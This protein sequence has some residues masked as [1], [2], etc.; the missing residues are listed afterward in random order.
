MRTHLWRIASAIALLAMLI[1]SIGSAY[2]APAES[3][4]A[5][6]SGPVQVVSADFVGVSQPLASLPANL[7]SQ[8][9]ITTAK[10]LRERFL[11]PKT[12]TKATGG[13]DTSIVQ[14]SPIGNSMPAVEANFA[15]VG[16]V[17][18]V[19]PP[20][21]NGDIGYDPISGTKYYMQWVNLSFQ[22][23]DVTNPAAVTSL[24]GP[25]A[26]NTLWAGT[27]TICASN[28]DG[29]PI[30]LFDHLANRWMISQF[31]LGFPDNFHQCVAVSTSAD[32]TGTWYLYDFKTSSSL[33]NDYPHFGVWPDGYY[34][35]VNQFDGTTYGWEG[36]GVAAFERDAMLQGL[37]AKM[38]YIDVGAKNINYG[39]MLP[40]DLDGPAPAPGTPNY[41]MEWDDSTWLGDPTDTLRI[42]E[43]RVNWATP[44]SST[45]GLN[46]NFAPNLI[47]ATAN[48]DPDMCGGNRNCIPQPGTTTKLDAIADRLM[49]RLQYRNFGSY[50][51]MVGN[52]TVDATSTDKAGVHWFEL[53]NSGSGWSMYQQGVYAPDTNNRWMG[54]IA[55][56]GSGNMALGYSVSSTSTYPS[57][58]YT[59]RLSGDP[60]NSLPQGESVLIAGGG[61]QTSTSGR[62]GDYSNMSVDPEDDCTFWYTQEYY[63]T[64]SNAGWLTRVGS[65]RF[66][67]CTNLPTGTLSGTVTNASGGAAIA[68]ATVTATGGYS[69]LTDAS[70][71]YTLAVP[72]GTYD[73]TASFYGF[74]S[75]TATGLSVTAGNTTTQ[76]FALNSSATYTISGKVTDAATGWPLYASIDIFGYPLGPIYTNPA[77]GTFSVN[78][79]ASSYTFTV[80]AMSG[81]YD[82]SV[83][84]VVVTANATQNFTLNADTLLCTAPGYVASGF[85]EGF[86]TWPLTGWSVV[87][88]KSSGLVWAPNTVYGDGNYTNG[89]GLAATVNSD[90]N[91]DIP[92]DTELRTPLIDPATL[93][94]KNLT[95]T[96]NYQDITAF[97][98]LDLDISINGGTAWTNVNRWTSDQ[99]GLFAAPG[100]DVAVDL[101]PYAT[102]PFILRWRY[103]TTEAAPWDWYAQIDNVSIGATCAPIASGGLVTGSVKDANTSTLVLNATVEDGSGNLA[104]LIDAS[105]D[106]ATPDQ[107]YIIGQPAGSRTLTAIANNYGPD[108]RTPT[109]VAGNTVAQD[110]FLPSGILSVA[111]TSLSFSVPI[112][113][114]ATSSPLTLSNMGSLGAAFDIFVVNGP[115]PASSP[116]ATGPFAINTRHVGPKNLNDKDA[117][118]VRVDLKPRG[119]TPL[120]A[121]DV[122]TSWSTGLTYPWGIGFNTDATDLWLGN[123]GAGGGDDLNYRFTV[124]G[125]NTGDT[126]DTAD[127]VATFAGDMTY[128]PF[129]KT[130]WQV[131]VGGDSCIYELDPVTKAATGEK[132]CPAFGTS[133]RGLAFDPV[134]NTYYAGSW[135]DGIINHFAPDGTILDSKS[136]SLD[137]SGLA[138]N[139]S[140]RHL[141]VLTNAP[142]TSDT[143]LYDVYVLD[144]QNAYAI[145]G[146]FNIKNG[147]ASI[148]ADYGQAG[149]ELDCDGNLWAVDQSANKVYKAASGE[150]GVCDWKSAWLSVTPATGSV[151]ASGN[152][153]LTAAVN[154]T[155]LALGTYQ[156]HVRIT[157]NTAYADKLIPVA[158]NVTPNLTP[159][160]IIL[161]NA[162]VGQKLPIGTL[163]GNL[164][165]VDPTIGDSFTY[166][167]V[168]GVGADN[169]AS[170]SIS[171]NQLRTAEVFDFATKNSYSIRVRSTDSGGLFFEKVFT[172]TVTDRSPIFA[173]VPFTYWANSYVERLY[174]AGITGGCGVN[175]LIYCPDNPVTRA[176]MAVFLLRGIHGASYN[177]PIASGTVF[178]DVPA[179][180]LFAPWIEQLA[181]EGITAGCGDGSTYCPDQPVT[182]AQMAVF[183]L[184]SKYG[185]SHVAPAI[186]DTGFGDVPVSY[187]AA[188]WIKELANEGIT[189]GCGNGNYCPENSVTRAEMA[190][191]LVKTFNLP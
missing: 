68:G 85:S 51:T 55:M 59:G 29:D 87:D 182:R 77:T 20:D 33:M 116:V 63:A 183:L 83:L 137:I 16:N 112:S 105:A 43:F 37:P 25:A 15:G 124:A 76:N 147:S 70:G 34:M 134:T 133:E 98:T 158:L 142:T 160:D 129:T 38:V 161:S 111:P 126:I 175:P 27:G 150:T 91:E 75:N 176:Q 13:L 36:A 90:E 149:L 40:T 78:L 108:T 56:D 189:A 48:V 164:T 162:S 19:L 168:N 140:T 136:V 110:F 106:P 10:E 28:N 125:V 157:S 187:W 120:A 22:I 1:S 3:I 65:F 17:N 139:P 188:R 7:P 72:V 154:A 96:A 132:I 82:Q 31:A 86:E 114:P 118:A 24:Y 53:R 174:L 4:P 35:T 11:V 159:T 71:V 8:K 177:P 173:D 151:D 170:F 57:I 121:G 60:L 99:G 115:V 79:V 119:V 155:G 143:T 185:A 135:T 156:A 117:S 14:N 172:I 52:H 153:A 152:Q 163:V 69:T 58:R 5:N 141:F 44:T 73:V 122:T 169:N 50:Q 186:T 146:A 67:S 131:N 47:V 138:Y 100:I 54:S 81:G 18:G 45:F 39:G 12:E 180:N 64:T 184:K 46:T 80:N 89:S 97:D 6:D 145:I 66:P 49:H 2:A 94:N 109:V 127:W 101:T 179:S 144:T 167:L 84:P 32:P 62:W 95:Y 171:G 165:T 148:F 104:T 74:I 92:Y 42:W 128:N 191:F 107:I 93:P 103:Y 61:S 123:I 113:A 178:S 41:F 190:V 9:E 181:K 30:V 21:T 102:A 23:W 88:N 130:L 26:G 166:S